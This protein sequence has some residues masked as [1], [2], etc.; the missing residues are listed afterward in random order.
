MGVLLGPK[1][2][3][4]QRC[5]VCV[6]ASRSANGLAGQVPAFAPPPMQQQQQQLPSKQPRPPPAMDPAQGNASRCTL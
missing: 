3:L 2:S 4:E 1:G 6:Q 5:T